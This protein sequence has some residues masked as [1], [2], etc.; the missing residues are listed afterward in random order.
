MELTDEIKKLL[1]YCGAD[2]I[3]IGDMSEVENCHFKTGIR[4]AEWRKRF[5]KETIDLLS[6]YSNAHALLSYGHFL[7]MRKYCI[8]YKN[9]KILHT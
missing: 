6:H 9:V 2:L 7:F 3:G 1:Y 5:T 4:R 8:F